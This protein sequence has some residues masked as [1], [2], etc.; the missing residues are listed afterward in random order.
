MSTLQFGQPFLQIPEF[1]LRFFVFNR[2]RDQSAA[3]AMPFRLP[4]ASRDR[5]KNSTQPSQSRRSSAAK[6]SSGWRVRS[7]V[8]SSMASMSPR[9]TRLTKSPAS[10]TT[11]STS[12]GSGFAVTKL[13]SKNSRFAS[14]PR[15]STIQRFT[16]SAKRRRRMLELPNREAV[17]PSDARCRPSGRYPSSRK[18]GIIAEILLHFRLFDLVSLPFPIV[19][20]RCKGR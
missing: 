5:L 20:Y 12:L 8:S 9:H 13:P 10:Q 14:T 11:A 17:S 1:R 7:M 4:S 6:I 2:I 19:S 15:E 18:P 16:R 3:S